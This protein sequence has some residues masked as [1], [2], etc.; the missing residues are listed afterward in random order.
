MRSPAFDSIEPYSDSDKIRRCSQIHLP[1][2]SSPVSPSLQTACDLRWYA[3]QFWCSRED[4]K[5][6]WK[7]ST[8]LDEYY[9]EYHG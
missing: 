9:C 3:L 7:K 6:S 5:R 8:I 2:T 1:G 4:I